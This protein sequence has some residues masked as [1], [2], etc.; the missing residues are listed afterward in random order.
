MRVLTSASGSSI[1]ESQASDEIFSLIVGPTTLA[2]E[3]RDGKGTR[4]KN[5]GEEHRERER[6]GTDKQATMPVT[7]TKNTNT[8]NTH[9]HTPH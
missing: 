9:H 3:D 8:T 7:T 1:S 6:R 4:E 2:S 5:G